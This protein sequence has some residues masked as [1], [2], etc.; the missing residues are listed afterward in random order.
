[1]NDK[2]F[3][4]RIKELED[5]GQFTGYASVFGNVDYQGEVVEKG[6]FKRTLDH[7][8]GRVPILWQHDPGEPIG[9]GT[10]MLEDDYG[11][12]V[13]G[14]IN[15]D[16]QRGREAHSLLR[17]GALKGLSI[18]YDVIKDT[19]MEGKRFLKEVRLHEYSLVTFAANNLAQVQTIKS[20]VPFQNLPLASRDMSWDKSVAL[21]KVKAW[22]GA[23]DG[24]N[25]KYRK[26][27]LWFDKEDA[28]NFGAYKL[29]IGDIV[30]GKLK[31]VPRAIFAAAAAMQGA[32]GGV[33]LPDSDRSGVRN[34]IARYYSSLDETPPW[35]SIIAGGDLENVTVLPEQAKTLREARDVIDALLRQGDKTDSGN[36]NSVEP[37]AAKEPGAV[38]GDTDDVSSLVELMQRMKRDAEGRQV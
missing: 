22:A 11:L 9:V 20:V 35:K 10:S 34:N 21:K 30:D 38:Q 14:K 7:S 18:G 31:A 3:K 12:Y 2:S 29:P 1:M 15:M 28:E 17:Q 25:A 26:A 37:T 8:S 32:R 36:T 24:P 19:I 5:T 4:L 13:E 33:M 6:A 23:E 16:T 27:F